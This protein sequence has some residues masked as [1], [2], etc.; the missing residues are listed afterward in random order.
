MPPP[1]LLCLRLLRYLPYL[2]DLEED[3]GFDELLLVS[4]QILTLSRLYS[5][6]FRREK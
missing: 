6:S 3:E 5:L 2:P 1:I 4:F